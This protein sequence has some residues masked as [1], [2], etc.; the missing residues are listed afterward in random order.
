MHKHNNGLKILELNQ[1]EV[2]QHEVYTLLLLKILT[3]KLF[4]TCYDK[5]C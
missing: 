1:L 2:N 4:R 3:V 5:I